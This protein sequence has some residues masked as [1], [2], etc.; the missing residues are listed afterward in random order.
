MG[1]IFTAMYDGQHLAS[2]GDVI[3]VS[4]AYR[5]GPFGFMNGPGIT[6]NLGLHDQILALKWIQENIASFGGNPN[7][8]TIFGESAGSISVGALVLSPLASG[9]FHRAIAQSGAPNRQSVTEPLE[10]SLVKTQKFAE[11]LNCSVGGDL[12]ETVR[13]IKGKSIDELQTASMND[14]MRAEFFAPVFGDSLLPL[15]PNDALVAGKFNPVDYM[16][17]ITRDEGTM[18]LGFFFPELLNQT[19]NLTVTEAKEYIVKL[20][21][22]YGEEAMG[23]EVADFYIDRLVNATQDDLK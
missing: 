19:T 5:L 13:C 22:V 10:T 12:T 15:R 2:S 3:V 20:M 8:V 16:Y 9:L 14:F 11:R 17:G 4:I 18:F 21:K 1:T 7:S 6:P 23:A